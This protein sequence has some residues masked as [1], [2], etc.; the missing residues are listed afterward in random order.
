MTVNHRRS[1]QSSD[2]LFAPTAS[3]RQF[4]H[5]TALGAVAFGLAPGGV[6]R[7][8][9]QKGPGEKLNVAASLAT[10]A[11]M[12]FS[13]T[14]SSAHN[15]AASAS[16]NACSLLPLLRL[17]LRTRAPRLERRAPGR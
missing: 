17:V 9:G 14:R 4:L 16:P 13:T 3:R 15:R 1:A 2:S 10:G 12:C 11:R 7:A 5:T 8:A 6:V